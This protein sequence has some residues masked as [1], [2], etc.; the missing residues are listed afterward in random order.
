MPFVAASV[1]RSTNYRFRLTANRCAGGQHR[2]LE[3]RFEVRRRRLVHVEVDA[4]R[5]AEDPLQSL[6]GLGDQLLLAGGALQSPT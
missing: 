6:L 4:D 3:Q 1:M 5:C 2:Q